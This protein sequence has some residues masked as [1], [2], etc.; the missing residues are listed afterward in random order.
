MT[1][2]FALAKILFHSQVGCFYLFDFTKLLLLFGL[3]PYRRLVHLW[4]NITG[5]LILGV[6]FNVSNHHWAALGAIYLTSVIGGSLA[7]TLFSPKVYASGA[8]AGQYGI[9]FAH[10]AVL[11]VSWHEAKWRRCRLFLLALYLIL[12]IGLAPVLQ[13]LWEIQMNVS[14]SAH[15]GGAV[16]GFLV[17]IVLLRTTPE[18]ESHKMYKKVSKVATFLLILALLVCIGV[19]VSFPSRYL[20][21]PDESLRFDYHKT[22]VQH[23]ERALSTSYTIK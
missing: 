5:Q 6:L 1:P 19:N 8:S 23:Y 3:D 9:L 11:G 10:M 17:T 2:D 16:T 20:H 4:V 18:T 22:H 21:L 15:A 13:I 7:I 12:D 14:N